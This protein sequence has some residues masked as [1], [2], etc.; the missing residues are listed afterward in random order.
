MKSA[1]S[2]IKVK[3]ALILSKKCPFQ[4]KTCNFCVEEKEIFLNIYVPKCIFLSLTGQGYT[5]WAQKNGTV[6][7]Q[8][9]ALINSYLF[10]LAG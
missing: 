6:D 9:F 8:Y 1:L 10:H 2:S 4:V 7:F 3:S 5:G